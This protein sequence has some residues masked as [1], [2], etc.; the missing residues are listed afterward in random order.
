[1]TA[2]SSAPRVVTLA[3]E[4]PACFAPPGQL[5]GPEPDRRP[6]GD[7]IHLVRSVPAPSMNGRDVL[8]TSR[9]RALDRR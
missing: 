7:G 4:C 8:R 1:M 3:V 9:W 5:C 2:T 6:T